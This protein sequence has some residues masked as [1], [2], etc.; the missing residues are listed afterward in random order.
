MVT[1]DQIRA[2]RALVRWS[3][4]DLAE[5]SGVSLNTVQ[6]MEAA[7]GIPG[8][9]TKT[10]AAIRAA[11]ESAGVIFIASNGDG[12]GVRLRKEGGGDNTL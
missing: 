11:L 5:R 6:R 8:G 4:K 9:L 2:A 3:A 7:D 10:L 12:P 1:S